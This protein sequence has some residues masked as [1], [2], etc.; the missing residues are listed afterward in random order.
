MKLIFPIFIKLIIHL[1]AHPT[2]SEGATGTEGLIIGE[3][4]VKSIG[5][6]AQ[7]G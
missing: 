6:V 3:N 2:L 7:L 1:T 5:V 4:R